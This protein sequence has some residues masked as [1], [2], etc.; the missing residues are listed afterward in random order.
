LGT[1]SINNNGSITA[2][3][4]NGTPPFTLYFNGDTV[5]TSVMTI[6][7]LPVGDYDVRIV[8]SSGC[9]KTKK[10]P[11]RGTTEYSSTGIYSV[12]STKILD[13]PIQIE[14]SPRQLLNEGYGEL[15]Q[16]GAISGFTN[17]VLTATTFQALV[18]A[19]T[20]SNSSVFYVGE[21]LNDYPSDDLWNTTIKTLLE[22]LP[23]IGSVDI[24]PITNT[25]VVTTNCEPESLV[26]TNLLVKLRINYQIA[27]VCPSPTPT[28]T[29][30]VTPTPSITP[31]H[32]PTHTPTQTPTN[33]VTPSI[34]PTHTPTPTITKTPFASPTQTPT[35]T[36]TPSITPSITS[37]HTPTP[38][39]TQT[40]TP[41][42]TPTPTA[43]PPAGFGTGPFIFNFDYR[44]SLLAGY[45]GTD[46]LEG[47]YKSFE[48]SK[49]YVGKK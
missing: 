44:L 9:S 30:T 39:R 19:G 49:V 14:T 33:T 45:A 34:T 22:S 21:T 46:I 36:P 26:N 40:V 32:T 12:C 6:P 28:N 42:H 2:Y 41:T 5:G 3:I 4:T 43:T 35:H 8:D 13:E 16:Q 11:I 48:V 17:C 18:T 27:C 29:P 31:T 1:N 38:T 47:I 10:R 23:P 37:T 25:V 24:N 7:D 15:I 20:Y